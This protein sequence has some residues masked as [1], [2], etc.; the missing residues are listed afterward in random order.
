[1]LGH[2]RGI[3]RGVLARRD[4]GIGGEAEARQQARTGEDGAGLEQAAALHLQPVARLDLLLPLRDTIL[5]H[6]YRLCSL[7]FARLPLL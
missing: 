2:G 5:I 4:A 1:M 6:N 7:W 3:E